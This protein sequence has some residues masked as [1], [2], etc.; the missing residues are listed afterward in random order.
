MGYM[1]KTNTEK[2]HEFKARMYA[3]GYKQK[4]VWVLRDPGKRPAKTGR[5]DFIRK[6]DELT[7]DWSPAKLSRVFGEII[8]LLRE[9]G[10]GAKGKK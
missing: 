1:A 9:R 7:A 3:A 5:L 4:Q 8:S 10:G 6:L 2:Q